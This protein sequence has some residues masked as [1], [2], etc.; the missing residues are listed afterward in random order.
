MAV[1]SE[2]RSH[3]RVSTPDGTRSVGPDHA[4]AGESVGGM[5][6][7]LVGP[8][9]EASGPDGEHTDRDGIVDEAELTPQVIV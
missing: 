4:R 7:V 6:T 2:E 8:V 3:R 1:V 9:R 5:S